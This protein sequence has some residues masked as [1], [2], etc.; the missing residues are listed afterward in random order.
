ML[1]GRIQN[2]TSDRVCHSCDNDSLGWVQVGWGKSGTDQMA[3]CPFCEAGRVIEFPSKGVGPWGRDGFWRG[4]D[5]HTMIEP[6][7]SKQPLPVRENLLRAKLLELRV[8]GRTDADPCVGL[9]EPNE[10][11]RYGRVRDHLRALA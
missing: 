4:R 8:H 11:I 5:P 7:R 3:P 1:E 10:I 6:N 2:M 9:D